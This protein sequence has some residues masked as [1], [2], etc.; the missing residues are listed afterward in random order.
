MRKFTFVLFALM[1]I[2]SLP[3]GGHSSSTADSL[4][5]L[6]QLSLES[7]MRVE[8]TSVSKKSE[9]VMETAAAIYVLTSEDIQRSG[10]RTIPELLRGVPGLYVANVD[11]HNAVVSSRGNANVFANKLLVL[12][13][14][15]TIYAPLFSGVYWDIQDTLIDDIERIEVIR[16]PG[17]S[18]WGANAVNGVINIITKSSVDTQGVL[19]TI[20]VGTHERLLAQGRYGGQFS[21]DLSYRIYAKQRDVKEYDDFAESKATDDGRFDHGGFRVDY[22][23]SENRSLTLQGDLYQSDSQRLLRLSTTETSDF[24]TD[25]ENKGGNLLA[26]WEEVLSGGSQLSVQAYYDRTDR[27]DLYLGELRQT[28]DIDISHQFEIGTVQEI[29]WGGGYR[30]SRDKSSPG[31]VTSVVPDSRDDELYNLFVQDHLSLFDE[32]LLVTFGAKYERNDYTGSEWQPSAR[33]TWVFNSRHSVWGAVSRA[34]RTPSRAEHNMVAQIGGFESIESSTAFGIPGPEVPIPVTANVFVYGDDNFDSEKLLAYELGYRGQLTD[35]LYIDM[36][37][38]Y[39]DYDQLRTQ[40]PTTETVSFGPSGAVITLPFLIDNKM[41]GENIGFEVWARYDV[42]EWW[43]LNASYSWLKILL[44]SSGSAL[45]PIGETA[46]E[47]DPEHQ[48]SLHSAMDLTESLTL[49]SY[50]YYTSETN[51]GDVPEF[52]RFDVRLAWQ[53]ASSL[54]WSVHGTN[55]FDSHHPEMPTEFGSRPSEVPR[56]VYTQL[57]WKY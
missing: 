24:I 2:L 10:Y 48:L 13:D 31:L 16:G 14:G 8:V 30:Y 47:D 22:L 51:D 34:V 39:H 41:H 33:A 56:T 18:T 3:C 26:R 44:H 37:L 20:G 40:E 45:D 19:A 36:S 29:V 53:L 52:W 32:Q 43:R 35:Q 1:G 5:Y 15:R 27:K 17:A 12:I 38:F 9:K 46:E 21:E 7:L 42:N 57:S 4:V 54:E 11:S 49:D 28:W 25:V 23:P 55:L 50:L 6:K